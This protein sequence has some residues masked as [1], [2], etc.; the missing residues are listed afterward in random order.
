MKKRTAETV[1][2]VRVWIET[3][4]H[5]I[6]DTEFNTPNGCGD[7]THIVLR[8]P[9]NQLRIPIDVWKDCK[10]IT[11]GDKFDTRVYRWCH[12]SEFDN[13]WPEN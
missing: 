11:P 7:A 3:T 6:V 5:H 2:Q 10:V 4:P 1:D 9:H 13:H 8:G 12:E